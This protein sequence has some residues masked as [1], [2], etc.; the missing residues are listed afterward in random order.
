MSFS[1]KKDVYSIDMGGAGSSDSSTSTGKIVIYAAIGAGAVLIIAVVAFFVARYR[2][3]KLLKA[4]ERRREQRRQDRQ[5]RQNRQS[6]YVVNGNQ[7]PQGNY[8]DPRGINIGV[9]QQQQMYAMPQQ[10]YYANNANPQ[11]M[12]MQ[13]GLVYYPEANVYQ[14]QHGN[15]Y[16]AVPVPQQNGYPQQV[17]QAPR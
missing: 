15:I 2:R 3:A 11:M 13:G 1:E 10:Q 12:Q 17:V 8:V 14:D 6:N 16:P 5:S 4:S 7:P 9:Q